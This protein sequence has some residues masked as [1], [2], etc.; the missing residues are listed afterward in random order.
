MEQKMIIRAKIKGHTEWLFREELPESPDQPI[1]ISEKNSSVNKHSV[2]ISAYRILSN[3]VFLVHTEMYFEDTQEILWVIDSEAF[4]SHFALT[5]NP[6]GK[7]LSSRHNIRYV[8]Q[9]HEVRSVPGKQ[10]CTFFLLV[11]TPAFYH[12]FITVHAPLHE[13]FK[14]RAVLRNQVSMWDED[15][16]ATAGMLDTIEKLRK[17]E[18]KQEVKQI[19][20]TA[21]VLELIMLQFEQFTLAVKKQP[22]EMRPDDLLKLE[23]ARSILTQQYANP[24]TQK[25]LSKMVL[26]NE[27]K[28][29]NGFKH[30]FG[31]TIY[32][33]ITQLRMEEA[34]RL[35]LDEGKNMYEVGML[36]GFRHQASFTHAFKKYFGILPSEIHRTA[37][38]SR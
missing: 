8:P 24:P 9:F 18:E 29:R 15:L 14:Q 10:K 31:T 22:E 1:Q 4:I 28:L 23:E 25:K 11:M 17:A 3:G 34:K 7:V 36:V 38:A 26:L 30:Y 2:H 13:R 20:T 37:E 33:Y 27:F 19:Y 6:F 35:I 21:K 32:N 12:N 5:R 16:A